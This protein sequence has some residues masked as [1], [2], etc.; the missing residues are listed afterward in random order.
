MPQIDPQEAFVAK[1]SGRPVWSPQETV[2]SRTG[3]RPRTTLD[4]N[5]EL[6]NDHGDNHWSSNVAV[7]TESAEDMN[8]AR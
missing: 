3:N 8:L 1:C 7:S 2:D 4:H 5:N 6:N